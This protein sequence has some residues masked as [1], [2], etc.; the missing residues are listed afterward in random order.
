MWYWTVVFLLAVAV[1]AFGGI[2]NSSSVEL[3]F[4]R[5]LFVVA[6]SRFFLLRTFTLTFF[7]IRAITINDKQVLYGVVFCFMIINSHIIRSIITMLILLYYYHH[8]CDGNVVIERWWWAINNHLPN[9]QLLRRPRTISR[10]FSTEMCV[11][12]TPNHEGKRIM[13]RE[14][15][16][17]NLL[18]QKGNHTK[19]RK[20]CN[21]SKPKASRV[22][23]NRGRW[24][25]FFRGEQTLCGGFT[26]SLREKTYTSRVWDN[27]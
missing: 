13:E 7:I 5:I 22:M 18:R 12:F 19:K 9:I 6:V 23:Y 26:L 21:V 11:K 1:L 25:N 14:T 17:S 15:K 10:T 27:V 2:I 8:I 24:K 4:L 20:A 16:T 3:M